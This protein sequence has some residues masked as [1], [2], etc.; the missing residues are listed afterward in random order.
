[1]SV[2]GRMQFHHVKVGDTL[3]KFKDG[4]QVPTLLG[5]VVDRSEN[6]RGKPVLVLDQ[7]SPLGSDRLT[8]RAFQRLTIRK[9]K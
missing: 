9:G 2:S 4:E 3:Y 5:T 7:V 6:R 1:M 8:S